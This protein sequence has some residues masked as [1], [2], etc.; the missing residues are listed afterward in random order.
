MTV[1]CIA[2]G[3]PLPTVTIYLNG[4]PLRSEVT[5]HMVTMIHNVTRDMGQVSCY[6][7]NGYGTPMQVT[8]TITI[9]R[10]PTVTVL[11]TTPST[12]RFRTINA[13]RGDTVTITCKVDAFPAPTMAVFRD[14]ELKQSVQS[15]GQYSIMAKGDEEDSALFYL[16]FKIENVSKDDGTHFFCHANN[17]L[18]DQSV[19]VKLNI[20]DVPPPVMDMRSC[21]SAQ[22]VS[23]ACLSICSFS[24]DLDVLALQPNCLPELGLMMNCASDGS[25][26]RHCCTQAGVPK[27]CLGWCRGEQIEVENEQEVCAI[28][29]SS[30]ILGC[31]HQGHTNLPGPPL[32]V[33]VRPVDKNSAQVFWDAPK[34]N[35]KSVELYRVFWSPSKSRNTKKNDT[36]E[37]NL[38]LTGLTSGLTYELVVKAGNSNGTSQ[39]TTPLKFV[40]ADEFIIATSPVKSSAGGTI[41]LVVAVFVVLAMIA[42]AIYL[43]KRKNLLLIS[44]KKPVSPSVSFENPLNNLRTETN[45]SKQIGV[46]EEYN[47]HISSSGSW[48]S[49]MSQGPDSGCSSNSS[50][51]GQSSPR[52]PDKKASTLSPSVTEELS[53]SGEIKG[54]SLINKLKLGK[55]NGFQ[56]FK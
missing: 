1:L 7:D 44:F 11:N 4:H 46:P 8:R 51:S 22:N 25:D 30:S 27:T 45:T 23:T 37:Q 55:D 53:P 10:K 39:L 52:T 3:T 24:L 28:E 40:T 19:G 18:G 50:S 49:E 20:T 21:C 36:V 13:V 17:T 54:P 2:M 41:G 48:Q 31:F 12:E 34:K 47:V 29:H 26:H 15:E 35:P 5:R 38:L 42:I 9:S 43:M 14:I 16:T 6:A 56:R 32:N 33:R